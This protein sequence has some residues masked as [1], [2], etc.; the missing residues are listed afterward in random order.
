MTRTLQNWI[1]IP[2]NYTA[3]LWIIQNAM[4]NLSTLDI[5]E[6]DIE[7][8]PIFRFQTEMFQTESFQ[9]NSAKS[10]SFSIADFTTK[11]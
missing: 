2:S 5:K 1:Q 4:Q 3:P 10:A 11:R 8:T 7:K 6:R 9:T